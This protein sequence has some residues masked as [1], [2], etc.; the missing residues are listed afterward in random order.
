MFP[1]EAGSFGLDKPDP[2]CQNVISKSPLPVTVKDLRSYLGAYRTFFRCKKQMSSILRSLEELQAGRKSSEKLLWTKELI[3]RFE[4]S[5]RQILILDKLYLPKPEDQL[6]MT[7]DWSEKGISCTL[8]AMIDNDPKIVTRFSAKLEKSMENMITGQV[9][10]KTLPCDGEMTAVY[11]GIKSPLISSHIKASDKQTV[12]LVDNKPVVEAARLIKDGRFSSSRIINNLMTAL[13]DYNLE[14]QHLS[15]KMEQNILDDFGSRNAASCDNNPTCKICDF[16]KDC[17]H[18]TI[19]PVSFTVSQNCLIGNIKHSE[20]LIHDILRGE[21]SIP[22]N[23]RKALRFL[24]EQDEDLMYLEDCLITGKRPQQK[25]TK[26]NK[27]KRYLQKDNKLSIAKDGCIIVNNRDKHFNTREQIVIPDKISTGL[28]YALHLNLNHPSPF[29]LSKILDTRFFILDKEKKIREVIDSCALCQS[30]L[31]IPREIENFKPNEM[32]DHPGQA[33]TID[34]L[35]MNKKNILVAVENFSGYISTTFVRSENSSDLLEG[36]IAT[37]SPFRSSITTNIRVDQAPGF[38]SLS[39]HSSLQ[40]LNISLEL[41]EAKNKNAVA[42]VDKKIKELEDEIRK[43]S[44]NGNVNLIIL[45]KATNIVNEKIRHQGLSAKEIM[46]S[47]DQFSLE[48]LNLN[49]DFLAQDKMIK[50][51]QGNEYS[52]KSKAQIK[53]P[54]IPANAEKGQ[55]V[56]MK[57]EGNKYVKRDLYMVLE[58]DDATQ[59]LMIAKLPY[60]LS[61]NQPIKFQPHNFKYKVKQTDILLSPNQPVISDTG[62]DY[63][64]FEEDFDE[65]PPSKLSLSSDPYYP[66]EHDDDDDF[67]CGD[68]DEVSD[69]STDFDS[70]SENNESGQTDDTDDIDADN[71]ETGEEDPP[72][73]DSNPESILERNLEVREAEMND[74]IDEVEGAAALHEDEFVLDQSRQPKKGDIVTFVYGESWVIGKILSKAKS[75]NYYNVELQNSAKVGVYFRPPTP[76]YEES[77]SLLSEDQWQP[78]QLRETFSVIGSKESSPIMNVV[79]DSNPPTPHSLHLMPEETIHQGQVYVIPQTVVVEQHNQVLR[80]EINQEDFDRRYQKHKKSLNLSPDQKH[81]EDGLIRFQ[82]YNELY[83]EQN[84]LSN[85]IKSI[86]KKKK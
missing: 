12:C 38:R 36:I 27:V 59:T 44:T 48:N 35:K 51:N 16:V 10:P 29:Q 65:A 14:F 43:M 15:A 64:D 30:V 70:F 45:T 57:H 3:E 75:S 25:N 23:N 8:W 41:G 56:M 61:G 83:T 74:L 63:D 85:K 82:I 68:V 24:Q 6:V 60:A 32:P 72:S 22:F 19:A 81:L 55:I 1:P 20:N 42:I 80:F 77:W 39:K 49:D 9:K 17:E 52:S 58:T 86:F 73:N 26:V 53:V 4:E 21:V 67:V 47:R 54:A 71:V 66:Y 78:D 37:T 33:F 28:I 76:E 13:S 11:V 5:K 46:F 2:H 7:S 69:V 40:D 79:R 34:V 62:A 84:S 18:L 31:K 50:R